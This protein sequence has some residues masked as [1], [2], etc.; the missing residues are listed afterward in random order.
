[1]IL[2]LKYYKIILIRYSKIILKLKKLFE[3]IKIYLESI[4]FLE[5][6]FLLVRYKLYMI[7]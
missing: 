4:N 3:T 1:M 6:L 2:F 7:V 5:D